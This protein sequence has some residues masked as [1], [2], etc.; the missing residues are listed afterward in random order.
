M[1]I[2][3]I[4]ASIP[5]IQDARS[6]KS[7]AISGVVL[8]KDEG[9]EVRKESWNYRLVIGMLNYLVNCSHPELAFSVRQC[10]CFLNNPKFWH[11][12][13]VKRILRYLIH[14]HQIGKQGIIFHP[15]K[16]KSFDLLMDASF[17]GERNIA[18][19]DKLSS[20]M[21]RTGYV[22]QY[23]SCPIIWGPRLQMEITFSTIKS[24]HI[25]LSQSLRSTN[26]RHTLQ[27]VWV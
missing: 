1:L 13:A 6:A 18:W 15:G 26:P 24:E 4:V 25:M 3:W 10:A 21:L 16:T 8:I 11:G 9:G 17:S 19:S 12:Q 7:P 20:V 27:C 23:A 22:N 2:E 14:T 5:E